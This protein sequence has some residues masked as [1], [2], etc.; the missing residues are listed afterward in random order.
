MIINSVHITYNVDSEN[1]EENE[2]TPEEKPEIKL[3]NIDDN[4]YKNDRKAGNS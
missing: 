3:Q 4:L 1:Y 2:V